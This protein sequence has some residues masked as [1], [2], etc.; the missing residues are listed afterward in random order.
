M[1][2]YGLPYAVRGGY[3]L[4]GKEATVWSRAVLGEVSTY[5]TLSVT[6]QSSWYTRSGKGIQ[7]GCQ[8]HRSLSEH[9]ASRCAIKVVFLFRLRE[10]PKVDLAHL[11]F[12][13]A[14]FAG[15]LQHLPKGRRSH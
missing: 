2:D 14:R 3:N 15:L 8:Q 7:A 4:R 13:T 5:E 6:T 1:V 10:K 11:V 9:S 12:Q